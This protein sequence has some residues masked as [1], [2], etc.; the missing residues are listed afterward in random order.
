[1]KKLVFILFLFASFFGKSQTFEYQVLFHGIG[2]NREYF[3]NY[4][5]PQTILGARSA[6]E[7]GVKSDNHR[8]RGGLSHF[9]EFGSD[10]VSQLPLITLYYQFKSNRKEFLFGSFP[11]NG[12][13]NFPLAMLTDTLL[14]Y[15][16]NMEGIFG[17]MQWKWG[18]QNAFID[19]ISR[20]TDFNR[21]IFTAGTS[22][23]IQK[24]NFFLQNYILLTHNALPIIRTP[25]SHI[26]DYMGFALQA[27]LRTGQNAAFNAFVKAGVLGSS[28]RDRGLDDGFQKTAGFFAEAFARYK[29]MAANSVL[30]SGGGHKF[31][32]GDHFYRAQN[33]LRTDFTWYFL[34]HEKVKGT[35]NYALHVIDWKELN[36]QQQLSI[37]YIFGN[38][39]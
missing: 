30:S 31:A 10:M 38:G 19:W 11:R 24:D 32:Y 14:Y 34:N 26:K 23:E 33:Y 20:Q 37:V 13:I 8:V 29:N 39:E 22:G 21:E 35:L 7:M 12:K 27:G 5:Y 2:D 28:F 18:H 9:N 25:D 16:P 17:E 4:G 1:M 36:Q 3:N 6:F 15:R